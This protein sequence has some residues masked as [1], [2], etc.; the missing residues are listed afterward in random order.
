MSSPQNNNSNP[1][2]KWDP[3]FSLLDKALDQTLYK[4]KWDEY[5]WPRDDKKNLRILIQAA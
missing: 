3:A 4:Q 2:S 5:I 1:A